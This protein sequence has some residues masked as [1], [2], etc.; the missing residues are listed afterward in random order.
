M[1]SMAISS[2]SIGKQGFLYQMLCFTSKLTHPQLDVFST[3]LIW[4]I[5]CYLQQTCQ[6]RLLTIISKVFDIMVAKFVKLLT[7]MTI[8]PSSIGTTGLIEPNVDAL[9]SN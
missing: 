8:S 2:K 6:S 9:K 5:S 3:S 7:R 1:K 4:C